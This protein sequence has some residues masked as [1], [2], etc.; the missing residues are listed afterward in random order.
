[1]LLKYVIPGNKIEMQ[2]VG[3]A[4][5]AGESDMGLLDK[6]KVYQTQVIE[7]LSED[8]MEVLMPMEKTKLILLPVGAEYDMRFFTPFGMYQCFANVMDRYKS[9]GQ[10]ILLM[11]LTSNLRK[12]QRREYYRL[13]CAL[14][15]DSR[16]LEEEEIVAVEKN[17]VMLTPGLPLK[18]SLIVDISGGGIRF[19]SNY[20]YEPESLIY[21]KYNLAIEDS[22]KEYTL[23]AKILRVRELENK[24]GTFEHRAQYI[25]IDTVDREEIIR[26]IFEEDRKNRRR[27]KK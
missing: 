7:V 1:M 24:P 3:R 25:N 17:D 23:V 22:V 19:V 10:Y 9:N 26:F 27:L 2:A 18:H 14:E 8:R 4:N 5:E 11:E 6:R 13:S 20:A 15:M 12:H 16:P 21:C